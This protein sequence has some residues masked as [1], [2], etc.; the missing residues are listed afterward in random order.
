MTPPSP[1][2]P[3]YTRLGSRYVWQSRW[4]NVR[5]DRLRAPDGNELTYTVIEK[6]EA[7]WIVP[8]TERG[9]LVLID[10]YRYPIG[11]WCLEVP[12]GNIEQGHTAQQMAARELRE[13]I[14]GEAARWTHVADFYTMNGIGDERA[15]VFAALGVR[16]GT[17]HRE[18]TEHIMRRVVP[19]AE[20]LAMARSG[21][22]QDGPSALAIL[23]A[24]PILRQYVA[25][26][27]G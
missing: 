4:Y 16:L 20:G 21:A 3:N 26:L 7:V 10:Q 2:P 19:L 11:A 5:Q 17:P 14:G 9:E 23:L 12:A 27:E 24:E 6:P 13:E 8:L 18:P 15:Q 22:I 25:E 1:P